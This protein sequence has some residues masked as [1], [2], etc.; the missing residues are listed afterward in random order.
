MNLSVPLSPIMN[1]GI[2][3]RCPRGTRRNKITGLCEPYSKHNKKSNSKKNKLSGLPDSLQLY[4]Q[5]K[6]LKSKSNKSPASNQYH[7]IKNISK[8]SVLNKSSSMKKDTNSNVLLSVLNNEFILKN[9][10]LA[11]HKIKQDFELKASQ[12]TNSEDIFQLFFKDF[13]SFFPNSKINTK[14]KTQ[15]LKTNPF[16]SNVMVINIGISDNHWV[17]NDY[18]YFMRTMNNEVFLQMELTNNICIVC[19]VFSIY[20]GKIYILLTYIDSS[21]YPMIE[22]MFYDFLYKENEKY[23]DNHVYNEKDMA[24]YIK[25][26]MDNYLRSIEEIDVLTNQSVNVL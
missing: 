22:K 21:N 7:S 2:K 13:H 15:T 9:S 19:T 16:L 3:K 20:D 6:S 11:A 10:I 17:I 1:V 5:I 4:S 23:F 24:V 18:A 8:R 14:E 26:L 25:I 12:L